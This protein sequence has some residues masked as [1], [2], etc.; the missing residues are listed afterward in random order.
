MRGRHSSGILQMLGVTETVAQTAAEYVEIAVRLGLELEWRQS[1]ADRI[2]QRQAR[3]Y[4]DKTCVAALEA[5]YY[6][7]VESV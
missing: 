6:R 3:L 5:F 4:G 1:I 2:L 7:A